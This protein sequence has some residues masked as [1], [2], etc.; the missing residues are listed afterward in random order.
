MHDGYAMDN[1]LIIHVAA[2]NG[3]ENASATGNGTITLSSARHETSAMV[4]QWLTGIGVIV[5]SPYPGLLPTLSRNVPP[6]PSRNDQFYLADL[7][8]LASFLRQTAQ[9]SLDFRKQSASRNTEPSSGGGTHPASKTDTDPSPDGFPPAS[10]QE[11][12]IERLRRERIGQDIY[13]RALMAYWHGACAVTGIKMPEVLRASHA[14]P[15]AECASDAE[16]LD[17]F[18]GF[19]LVANLDALFDRF[20]ISFDEGGNLLSSPRLPAADMQALGL[21][22]EMKLRWLE[23][24]HLPYLHW[25]RQRFLAVNCYAPTSECQTDTHDITSR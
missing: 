2:N 15:W 5:Q 21:H 16:R 9:L 22:P 10:P 19:L 23:K 20:L 14:K 17:V 18:N 6:W 12:E 3:F 11:T 24:E 1:T 8:Q 13:R 4:N 7:E 25:H